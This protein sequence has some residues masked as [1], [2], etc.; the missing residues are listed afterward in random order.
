MQLHTRTHYNKASATHSI[1]SK[2]DQFLLQK[3]PGFCPLHTHTHTQICVS[4]YRSVAKHSRLTRKL[5]ALLHFTRALVG[6]EPFAQHEIGA[7]TRIC[8]GLHRN[9]NNDSLQANQ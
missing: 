1:I 4:I 8:L 3:Q 2:I 9:S 6:V 7:Y 5:G